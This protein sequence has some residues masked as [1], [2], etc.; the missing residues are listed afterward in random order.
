MIR[1]KALLAAWVIG[2]FAAFGFVLSGCSSGG[3]SVAKEYAPT[4]KLEKWSDADWAK[5]LDAVCTPD[6]FVKID[7]LVN[8]PNGCR[9]A[10]FRYV[11]AIN[12]ASPD[13]RADLFPN[14]G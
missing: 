12:Q 3:G 13:N 1:H 10:L 6:G 5:V 7:E 4:T 14:D 9:D 11:G 2:V 8:N